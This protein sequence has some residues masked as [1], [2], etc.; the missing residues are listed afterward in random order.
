[1]RTKYGRLDVLINNAAT[2]RIVKPDDADFPAG[3]DEVFDANIT[4]IALMMTSLLPLLRESDDARVVNVSSARG[5]LGNSTTGNLP[6]TVSVPCCV[7]KTDGLDVQCIFSPE[8]DYF[9]LAHHQ[10]ATVDIR[11]NDTSL[12]LC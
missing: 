11:L 1:V 4:S 6:P 8:I 9:R 10:T 3:Y 2:T 7:S 5:S 12:S